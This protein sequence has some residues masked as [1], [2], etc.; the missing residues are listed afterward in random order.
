[1]IFSVSE[2]GNLLTWQDLSFV[3]MLYLRFGP[4]TKFP[5][6]R[7]YMLKNIHRVNVSLHTF[8]TSVKSMKACVINNRVNMTSKGVQ[9]IWPAAGA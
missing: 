3:A 8:I 9:R 7:K 4:E 2:Y 1:M 5:L 6:L